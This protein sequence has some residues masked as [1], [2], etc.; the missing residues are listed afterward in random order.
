MTTV[1]FTITFPTFMDF[2]F[3]NAKRPVAGEI[4]LFGTRKCQ[5]QSV[6]KEYVI[7]RT[8]VKSGIKV[9]RDAFEKYGEK[10]D[11]TDL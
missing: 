11:N 7:V 1:R 9:K 2:L 8:R 10:L 4:W 3:R 6:G 5:I